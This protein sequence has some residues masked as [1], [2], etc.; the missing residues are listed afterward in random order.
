MKKTS[1][2]SAHRAKKYILFRNVI[3]QLTPLGTLWR[4]AIFAATIIVA[5]LI[6]IYSGVMH[7]AELA[8]V[9]GKDFSWLSS[10]SSSYLWRELLLNVVVMS[11]IFAIYDALYMWSARSYPFSQRFDAFLLLSIEAG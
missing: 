2:P 8:M 4:S 11:L 1:K 3:T 7:T 10:L 5:V 9:T 6:S